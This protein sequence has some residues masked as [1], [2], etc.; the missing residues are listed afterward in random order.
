MC[1]V[2]DCNIYFGTEGVGLMTLVHMF[3]RAYKK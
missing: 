3:G 1:V 2:V